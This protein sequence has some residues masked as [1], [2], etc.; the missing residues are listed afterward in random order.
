MGSGVSGGG[1]VGV[2]VVQGMKSSRVLWGLSLVRV[3]EEVLVRKNSGVVMRK[4]GF[5]VRLVVGGGGGGG[6][7]IVMEKLT[8]GVGFLG[9]LFTR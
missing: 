3:M 5:V 2:R 6:G 7:G 9:G 1:R 8:I 4:E